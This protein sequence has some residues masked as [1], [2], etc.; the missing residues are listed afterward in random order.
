MVS[1]N[2]LIVDLRIDNTRICSK[3]KEHILTTVGQP[4]QP[5]LFFTYSRVIIYF[6]SKSSE[7][8]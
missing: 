7:S 1:E 2:H 8:E 3:T 6:S 4:P 5:D